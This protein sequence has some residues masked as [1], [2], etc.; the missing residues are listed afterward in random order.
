M[1]D[2]RCEINGLACRIRW[3]L[4]RQQ[5]SEIN[6]AEFCPS[7]Y[8]CNL[9]AIPDISQGAAIRQPGRCRM[10]RNGGFGLFHEGAHELMVQTFHILQWPEKDR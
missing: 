6:D 3:I 10:G 2:Q 8:A 5:D 4:Y 9:W 1:R 7:R